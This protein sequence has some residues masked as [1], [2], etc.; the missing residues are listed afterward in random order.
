MAR[1]TFVKKARK[2][3]PGTDIKA[4]ESYYWWQF[5]NGPKRAQRERPKASQLTQSNFKSQ[6]YALQERIA[7]LSA[8]PDLESECEDIAS[9]LRNIGEECQSSFDNMPEGLQQG[10]VG[11]MLEQRVSDM[12]S[13]ADE[14][15]SIDFSDKPDE[16]TDCEACDGT[17]EVESGEDNVPKAKCEECDGTGKHVNEETQDT[18]WQDKL[19]EAQ[20]ID[21]NVEG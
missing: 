8:S 19:D 21:I 7:D 3:V 20:A 18:Y 12:E 2:D 16:D 9:E 11:Q 14:F 17:G 5:K 4:G 10:D 1:A 6:V 15:E 13:A